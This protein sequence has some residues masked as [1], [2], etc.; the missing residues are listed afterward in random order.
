[1][2][3][4]ARWT[5]PPERAALNE[6]CRS[7]GCPPAT[8]MIRLANLTPLVVGTEED[9]DAGSEDGLGKDFGNDTEKGSEKDFDAGNGA[10]FDAV[11]AEDAGRG[12]EADDGRGVDGIVGNRSF[13]APNTDVEGAS[14]SSLSSFPTRRGLAAPDIVWEGESGRSLS[15]SLI[16]R[17]RAGSDTGGAEVEVA[18]DETEGL[19][20]FADAGGDAGAAS[21]G[22]C[23]ATGMNR[24]ITSQSCRETVILYTP[25]PLSMRESASIFGRPCRISLGGRSEHFSFQFFSNSGSISRQ[26]FSVI[27]FSPTLFG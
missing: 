25:M 5:R 23:S 11:A 14:R 18:L 24:D 7:F 2:M 6:S 26:T 8:G 16:R 17:G 20:F 21:G 3:S 27:S 15:S 1:M 19:A 10:D 12:F 13:Q 22:S 4:I 9:F